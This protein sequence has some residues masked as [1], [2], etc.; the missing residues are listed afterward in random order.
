MTREKVRAAGLFPFL[1]PGCTFAW[2]TITA[3]RLYSIY[4]RA[5]RA[6]RTGTG[7]HFSLIGS[8]QDLA[9]I[10]AHVVRAKAGRERM[11]K[12][13]CVCFAH[14]SPKKK[15]PWSVPTV[16]DGGGRLARR[17]RGE[18]EP[19]AAGAN[20]SGEVPCPRRRHMPVS[21]PSRTTW[22]PQPA[23]R[24]RMFVCVCVRV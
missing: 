6:A 22:Q 14:P 24:T 12:R 13:F 15:P 23:C 10:S 9:D 17:P 4:V 7:R 21:F 16:R 18:H 5:R 1:E 8:I 2:K 11:S 3:F 19:H 20:S